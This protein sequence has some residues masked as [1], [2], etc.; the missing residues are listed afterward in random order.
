MLAA[1]DVARDERFDESGATRR[2]RRSSQSR[3]GGSMP[4]SCS[5]S[6]TDRR[7]FAGDDLELARQVAGAARGALERS[8]L[9][10]AERTARVPVAAA[11]PHRQHAR[12]RARPGRGLR[13]GRRRGGG[14]PRARTRLRSRRSRTESSWSRQRSGTARRRRSAPARPPRGGWRVTWSRRVPRSPT[15]TRRRTT[16]LG[17]SDA[18]LAAGHARVPR[19]AAHGPRGRAARRA[20]G[21]RALAARVARGGDR[22]TRRARG[23]RVGRPRRTRS[24]TSASP[25]SASRASRSSRTSRTGSSRSTA[26]A[27]WSSGTRPPSEITGVPAAEAIG[28]TPAQVLQREPR[29]RRG[30]HEPARR[31]P[32]RRR[33]RLAVALR[34]GHARPARRGRRPHLRVPRHL[35]RA[36]RRADE[37]GVRLDGLRRAAHAADVDLRLRADAA[38][39]GRRVRRDRAA[40]VPRTSSRA[41]PS[42]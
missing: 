19:R 4:V 34:G 9:F 11:R 23:E 10:E 40:D 8:H 39:R 29:V 41:S 26:R 15:P 7:T 22:G 1:P 31:D 25:S 36:R 20:L 12:H 17:E 5:C 28:R 3:F 35:R 14:A 16:S 32:A 33:R 30:R 21:L 6:S 37:V 24:S 13:G 42:G 2:S 38:S 27:T 18:L